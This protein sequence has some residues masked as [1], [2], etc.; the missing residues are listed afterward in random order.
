[1]QPWRRTFLVL[2]FVFF[3]FGL[4]LTLS[5]PDS[6]L[7]PF[8]PTTCAFHSD[9]ATNTS[10]ADLDNLSSLVRALWRPL[11]LPI[12]E[13]SFTTYDGETKR[14]PPESELAHRSSLGSRLLI[15]DVDTRPH[16]GD[17]EVFNPTTPPLWS[18]LDI[19]SAGF[20]SH[21]LYAMI[22][23][24]SYK[25][26]RAPAYA[27]RAPHWV[28]VIFTQE[29][30]KQYEYVVMVDFDA[31]FTNPA[32][33]I[34]WLMNYW[35]INDQ[36][37]V[38]M[39]ED[40]HTGGN[41]DRKGNINLNSGFV[42]AHQSDNAQRLFKDWAE[43]PEETRYPGC[44]HYKNV[45]FHE[46][47]GFSSFVRYDFLDGLTVE[48]SPGKE[49]IRQIPCS[50]A[51]GGPLPDGKGWF[52][53]CK[54]QFVRHLWGGKGLTPQQLADGVMQAFV[55]LLGNVFTKAQT[56]ADYRGSKLEG[57]QI[58]DKSAP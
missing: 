29:M 6:V 37:M 15:L 8:T 7:H 30:L 36:V 2:P 31:M 32:V 42:I 1:M 40:P 50:E 17:G 26:V 11:I 52:G 23:G 22:H 53:N 33:P 44:A 16:V 41:A 28:K 12:T 56:V 18:N 54:G 57:D 46:Q 45:M 51:N 9:P 24:Y 49:M 19:H 58:K 10:T 35:R 13:P 14:L 39:A 25:F 5:R 21:S 4:M 3:V 43:C 20:L 38:A 55:P 34:E 48:K 27:D 47:S